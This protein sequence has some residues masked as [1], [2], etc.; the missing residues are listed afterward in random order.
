M[1]FSEPTD[2]S[3]GSDS[4]RSFLKNGNTLRPVADFAYIIS[5]REVNHTGVSENEVYPPVMAIL[6]Q[7]I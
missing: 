5:S 6:N 7:F 3:E 1:V 4:T 2:M